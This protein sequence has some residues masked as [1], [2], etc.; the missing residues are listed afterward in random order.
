VRTEATWLVRFPLARRMTMEPADSPFIHA[1]L[2]RQRSSSRPLPPTPSASTVRPILMWPRAPSRLAWTW[3]TRPQWAPVVGTPRAHCQP[4][5]QAPG[6]RWCHWAGPQ[7]PSLQA[8]TDPGPPLAT[9]LQ[10]GCVCDEV[11]WHRGDWVGGRR[12]MPRRRVFF[13]GCDTRAQGAPA[14]GRQPVRGCPSAE[15]GGPEPTPVDCANHY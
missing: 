11:G 8:T 9:N 2:P 12:G 1:F 14:V 7:L 5:P 4:W 13:I 15:I 10:P 3:D 6:L